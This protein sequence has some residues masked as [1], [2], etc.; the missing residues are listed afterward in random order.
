[1]N[2]ETDSAIKNIIRSY[3]EIGA[4]NHIEGNNLP[5][6]HSVNELLTMIK[7]VLFPGYFEEKILHFDSLTYSIGQ[8]VLKIETTLK[9]EVK[10]SLRWYHN[11][12]KDTDK[13]EIKNQ[14]E[15]ESA[16]IAKQF[17]EFIPNLRK[18]L[19]MDCQAIYDGDPAAISEPEIILAYPGFQTITIYRIAHFL[20]K[21]KVPLIPRIMTEISHS[22]YGVDIHP[23]AQIGNYFCIDHGTGIVIGETAVLGDHVKLYQGV[24]IGALS[25]PK[26]K[27]KSK[28]HPTIEDNV[29]IYARTTIL[30]GDTII[31]KNSII[32]GNVWLIK[33]VPENSKIY[34]KSDFQ[35]ILAK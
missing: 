24:T 29:T 32:G 33:S 23:G 15:K 16:E 11:Q 20:Y 6:R 9:E 2:K 30:G 21:K 13:S 8:K 14:V 25:V 26:G 5:S 18:T 35:Q 27:S 22:S 19:L 4:I 34:L 28:R 12:Q 7:H 31:G 3:T 17:I 1:M 10:K